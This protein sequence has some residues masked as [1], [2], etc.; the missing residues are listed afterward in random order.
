MPHPAS[1]TGFART[2]G[3]QGDAEWIWEV[4]SVN[5][6]GLELRFRLPSGFD[7]LEPALRAVAAERLRRGNVTLNLSVRRDEAARITL[8]PAT[9]DQALALALDVARRIPGAE[10]PR[11][12]AILAL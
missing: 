12:E 9:L 8:D 7:A 11:A 10:P 1:M 2:Q 4:R 6:R 3:I 5:G